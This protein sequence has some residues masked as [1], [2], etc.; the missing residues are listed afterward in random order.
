MNTKEYTPRFPKSHALLL[1]A[2]EGLMTAVTAEGLMT[3]QPSCVDLWAERLN[4]LINNL[5]A[6][7]EDGVLPP[8]FTKFFWEDVQDIAG[9]THE[10]I[11]LGLLTARQSEL[12]FAIAHLQGIFGGR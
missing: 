5:T 1:E 4:S 3:A 12:T 6:L 2:Y 10:K 7:K 11:D 8:L 9:R